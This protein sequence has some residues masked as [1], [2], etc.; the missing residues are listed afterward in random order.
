VARAVLVGLQ[1]A[2]TELRAAIAIGAGA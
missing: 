2:V 1:A